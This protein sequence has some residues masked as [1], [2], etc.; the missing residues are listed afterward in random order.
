MCAAAHK[1]A[2][3]GGA[4][5]TCLLSFVLVPHMNQLLLPAC[6]FSLARSSWRP[7]YRPSRRPGFPSD[8]L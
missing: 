3:A 1:S 8:P 6:C 2:L 4:S 5:G 7:P